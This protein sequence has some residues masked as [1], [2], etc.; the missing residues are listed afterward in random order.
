MGFTENQLKAIELRNRNILVSAAAGSG[1]TSVLVERIIRRICDEKPTVDVDKLL[2]M[3]FTNAAAS[4]M[5]VRIRDAIEDRLDEAVRSRNE[6]MAKGSADLEEY[7]AYFDNLQRQSVLMH[8]AKITTIHGFCQSIIRDHFE[9][10]GIDPNFRVADENECK[11]LKMDAV[12]EC[13]EESYKE[14]DEAFLHTVECFSGNKND[15]ALTDIVL[16]LYNFSMASPNP[17][18]FLEDGMSVYKVKT[19][20]DFLNLECVS[21]FMRFK[22]ERINELL[23]ALESAYALINE[24]AKIEGYRVSIDELSDCLSNTK[25]SLDRKDMDSA[26]NFLKCFSSSRLKSIGDKG[27]DESEIQ[28]RDR[29]KDI[30]TTVTK[31]IEALALELKYP[32]CEQFEKVSACRENIEVI[33]KLVTEFKENFTAKKRYKK[34][35]DFNDME[36]MALEILTKN[37]EVADIYREMFEEIYVDEYQDSNLTQEILVNLIKRKEG[38]VFTV[39]D[40]KQSIY[41]F[42]MARPDLFIEKYD[43][44]TDEDSKQQR[45]LLNDNFRSRREVVNAVNEIFSQIMKRDFGKIEYDESA[46]LRYGA[47]YYDE[48]EKT[49][50][51]KNLE[52][53]VIQKRSESPYKAEIIL[54]ARIMEL[55][56]E[57]FQANIVANRINS[58]I[59]GKMQVYDKNLRSLRDI[60]FSDCVIL[61][62]TLKS[63]EEPLKNVLNG[64]GIPVSVTRSEG[65]F[66]TTEVQTALAFLAVVDNPYQDIPLAAVMRSPVG[67]FSDEDMALISASGTENN[68]KRSSLYLRLESCEI[69]QLKEKCEKLLRLIGKYRELSENMQVSELLRKF[70]DEEYGDFVRVMNKGVQRIA[71]L[72]MLLVKAEDFG[73]TSFTGLYH[74]MRYIDQIK[75]YEMDYGEAGVLGEAD[76]VVKIMTI[77]KSKGLEFPVCFVVGCEKERNTR[78]ENG[79]VVWDVNYGI[80]CE[81]VDLENRIKKPTL[82][83]SLIKEQLFRENLAEEMR[84]LYVAMTRARE[85]LFMVGTYKTKNPFE[86]I[87]SGIDKCSS[88]LDMLVFAS[89]KENGEGTSATGLDYFGITN[90][91]EM[92]I[93]ASRITSDI[94]NEVSKENILQ[95][96]REVLANE[97]TDNNN[98]SVI[99]SKNTPVFVPDLSDRLKF[100]YTYYDRPNMAQKLS[101]SDLKH[102]AMEEK[103][104]RGEELTQAGQSLFPETEPDKYIPKFMRQEGQT[105]KGGTFYGTAFHRILELWDYSLDTV[106]ASDV[107]DFASRMLEKNRLDIEQANAINDE[108]V[109]FFLNSPLGRRMKEAKDKDQLYREQPFILG[110]GAEKV[111]PQFYGNS[112]NT[113]FI[114]EILVQ[115]IIDAYFIE[116][117]GITIVDYKTDS[118]TS[119][120]ILIN[121]YRAQLEYYGMALSRITGKNIKSLVIY[122]S[123]LREEIVIG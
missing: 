55:S 11:L 110:V 121:R 95:N 23:N 34:I 16:N 77:H 79:R 101:V 73:K 98:D 93:L 8:N 13:F 44:Y 15:N 89:K 63:W 10:I 112:E 120:Q 108:D 25:M 26:A 105:Q 109:A 29:V 85:K 68:A 67:G 3:T 82:I 103:R 6:D 39:G 42:R 4:E 86:K 92:D 32:A 38:N 123:R 99:E 72:N 96:V 64:A 87:P 97:M 7:A 83:R 118:V 51:G 2:I 19:L 66:A 20:E 24:T 12:A 41:R 75:K 81:Y 90:E 53:G 80:G 52:A 27:L 69:A 113:S 122:S 111:Y 102:R 61:T 76:D 114:P 56:N 46:M 30:R 100:T 78:D 50:D 60:R 45:I 119:S 47:T 70:I 17:E 37:Q 65:Y 117:D 115:G 104:A 14:A 74:F 40:V 9:E 35:I 106:K 58:M 48:C 36:H 1:K 59:K 62:R 28:A 49:G 71:N 31:G 116:D 43:T 5:K 18:K 107:S 91:D 22:V 33:C 88:F 57:E 21:D 54:G 84:V 94:S